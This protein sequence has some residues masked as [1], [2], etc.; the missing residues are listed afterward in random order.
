MG[1]I[2]PRPPPGWE[3]NH[4]RREQEGSGGRTDV[5]TLG[6]LGSLVEVIVV[7]GVIGIVG[8]ELLRDA[9]TPHRPPIAWEGEPH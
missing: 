4:A 5:V 8:G 7:E 1:R 3:G 2:M 9:S 6:L